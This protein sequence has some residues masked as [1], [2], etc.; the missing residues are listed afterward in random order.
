MK[1]GWILLHR[2][3]EE[4]P[5][6]FSE[7]FTKA[8]A[9]IDLLLLANHEAKTISI[10]GNL[11]E[12]NRGEIGWSKEAL[13]ARWKW[14][15]G[16]ARRFLKWLETEQQI[17][18]QDSATLSK[19]TIIN[20]DAYQK[21]VQQTVQQKAN[22][23]P[24]D[25]TQTKNNKRTI[26]NLKKKEHVHF[27][28][29]WDAFPR[30]ENKKKARQAWEKINPSEELAGEI[31]NHVSRMKETKQWKEGCGRF[32]PHPTTYLNGERWVDDPPGDAKPRTDRFAHL[33]QSGD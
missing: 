23:K 26:K 18:Q 8:H 14:S 2:Q 30:K 11:I 32:V 22:R 13:A 19:I 15:R 27:D 29:F 12:I 31:I 24:T 9:W 10:R 17:V 16:K 5:L 4:W 3:I 20:Y 28:K 7:P 1:K 21:T 6:Y 33:T 25:G